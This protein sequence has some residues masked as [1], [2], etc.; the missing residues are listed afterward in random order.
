MRAVLAA[1]VVLAS[2]AP[3]AAQ[4]PGRQE[5]ARELAHLMLDEP[6]RRGLDRQVGAAL[7]Q[8]IGGAIQERLNRPLAESEWRT[9]SGI[10]SRFIADTLP[11]SRTEEI[12]AR[13][14][15]RHFT[16]DELRELLRFQRSEVGRKAARLTPV[17]G[18]ETAQAIDQEIRESANMPAL[19]EELQRAFPVLRPQES[20]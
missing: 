17:I 4:E 14:Y 10:V 6:S 8:V 11:Q 7:M 12:A 9:V 13:A 19:L 18:S 20:P 15:A 16:D 5:L 2:V 1:L 3:A